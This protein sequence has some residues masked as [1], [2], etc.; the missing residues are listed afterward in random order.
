ML[1]DKTVGHKKAVFSSVENEKS[2]FPQ[3]PAFFFNKCVALFQEM[4]LHFAAHRRRLTELAAEHA[5]SLSGTEQ[6]INE[7]ASRAEVV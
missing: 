1:N 3:Q 6:R 4:E 5:A 2:L 7:K